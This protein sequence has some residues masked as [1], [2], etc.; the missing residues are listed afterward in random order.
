LQDDPMLAALERELDRPETAAELHACEVD[1]RYPE[2][3]LERL[4]SLGL[5][6]LFAE[7]VDEPVTEAS[8][9]AWRVNALCA[10]TARRSGS[11]AVAIAHNGLAMLPLYIAGRP[12][13]L[14]EASSRLRGGALTALLLTEREHFS[15]GPLRA[16]RVRHIRDL[17]RLH[18]FSVVESPFATSLDTS[19]KS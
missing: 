9:S 15:Y 5:L 13:Q 19:E 12:E 2:R 4:Y 1:E 3:L 14:R 7:P 6:S 10:L 8:L 16:A 18:G 17:A 11:L